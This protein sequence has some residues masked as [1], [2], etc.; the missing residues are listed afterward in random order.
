M[1]SKLIFH[2][3]RTAENLAIQI[4]SMPESHE[5]ISEKQLKD[6]QLTYESSSE[7]T[8]EPRNLQTEIMKK[9]MIQKSLYFNKS[10]LLFLFF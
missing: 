4:N 7:D 6:K 3:K 2:V 1:I 9:K 10:Y 8:F 5:Q